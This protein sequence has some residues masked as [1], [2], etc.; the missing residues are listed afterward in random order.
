M[1]LLVFGQSGQVARELLRRCPRDVAPVFVGRDV[2]DLSAPEQ[3]ARVIGASGAHVVINAAAY[4][5]VDRAEGDEAGATVVNGAAPAAMARACATLA[6]PLLHLSTDYV[7]DGSGSMPFVS[8]QPRLAA[9]ARDAGEVYDVPMSWS[10][11][12]SIEASVPQ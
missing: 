6:V 8:E 1:K 3:C 7:F 2:A 12:R 10:G 11:G 5:A 9:V 4:T